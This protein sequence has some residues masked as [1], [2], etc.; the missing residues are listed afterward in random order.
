[1]KPLITTILLFA[2]SNFAISQD[3][4]E[5]AILYNNDIVVSPEVVKVVSEE[6]KAQFVE[7]RNNS[8]TAISQITSHLTS[9]MKYSELMEEN[10]L[11][12]EFVLEFI[13]SKEGQILE[14][15]PL[16]K[17]HPLV[18]ASLLECMSNLE[19]VNLYSEN[20]PRSLKVRIP[21]SFIIK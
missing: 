7:Y 9:N 11:E 21:I 19:K 15:N 13:I 2:L 17:I 1:M 18:H 3:T 12:A 6:K 20:I 8:Q 10:A 4:S 14:W 5:L 16:Q